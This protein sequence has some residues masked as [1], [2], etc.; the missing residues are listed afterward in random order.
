MRTCPDCHSLVDDNAV[1][2]DNC[3]FRLPPVE[4]EIEPT[5]KAEIPP[6][7]QPA[8]PPPSRPAVPPPSRPAIPP[9]AKSEQAG[10]CSSCG[11][12]NVP[13]EMFCQ[14]CGVQLAPVTSVPP[15]P[16]TPVGPP[17]PRPQVL[18]SKT[19]EEA[20]LQIVECTNCGYQNTD[21][22]KYCQNC[23]QPLAAPIPPESRPAEIEPQ[24]E[25]AVETELPEPIEVPAVEASLQ[26]AVEE[27]APQEVAP[28]TSEEVSLASLGS[29][30][31][32]EETQ[33]ES[34]AEKEIPMSM[35]EPAHDLPAQELPGATIEPTGLESIA[36]ALHQEE[37][38]VST[39]TS[40]AEEELEA[41]VPL[42]PVVIPPIE[43]AHQAPIV[44]EIR[45]KLVVR[46]SGVEIPLPAGHNELSIGRVDLVRNIFP[47]IDLT[48]YGGDTS[49]VSRL[50]A[51]L[52][53]Q[54]SQL[55]IE[56]LNSTNYTFVNRLRLQPGQPYLVSNGDEIRLGLLAMSYFTT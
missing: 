8:V 31:K 2:C 1:F 50:H 5:I 35:A 16:P 24:K 17:P 28:E 32:P 53:L 10:A 46:S 20:K 13:G 45:G 22:D 33:L 27:I 48:G 44:N 55:F 29:E 19:A 41:P 25:S 26:E 18:E 36:P 7:S 14:N 39:P 40:E 6:P 43:Q 37:P 47:D 3:G 52:I 15:P 12:I 54:G 21:K 34:T 38:A 51:R 30:M 49:G 42:P 23:G 9:A 56:D 4:R 11:F